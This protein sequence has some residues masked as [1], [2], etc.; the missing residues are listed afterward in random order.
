MTQT[1]SDRLN[2]IMVVVFLTLLIWTWAYMSLEKNKTLPGTLEVSPSVDDSVLTT[3]SLIDAEYRMTA[4]PLGALNFKGSPTR[5]SE[6][7]KKYDLLQ[8]DPDRERLNFYYVP[9]QDQPEGVFQLNLFEFIKE[10]PKT[11]ELALSLESCTPKQVNVHIEHLERTKI[12][13]QCVDEY[14]SEIPGAE[15]DPAFVYMYVRKGSREPAMVMLTSQ[16]IDLARKQPLLVQPYVNL[17]IAG[18]VRDSKEK[19]KVRIRSGVL[20]R[21]RSFQTTKP[22]GLIISPELQRKY[23]VTILNDKEIRDVT[24]IRATDEAF[25]AY[26]NVDFPFLIEIKESDVNLSEVPL[27]SI[28]YNFPPEFVRGGQIELDPTKLPR[29]AKI[30]IKPVNG[31]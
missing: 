6:L 12:K 19:V 17:G 11:H 25:A 29:T 22:V 3:F 30:T 15:P 27:K 8:N 28:I 21:Q 31:G 13:V 2:K 10:H 5:I 23:E 1:M 16:Q 9:P 4:V 26:E 20:L 7:E 24:S 18:V 14:G